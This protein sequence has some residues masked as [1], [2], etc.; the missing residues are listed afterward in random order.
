MRHLLLAT[1]V[2]TTMFVSAPIPA[3]AHPT[4]TPVAAVA[5]PVTIQGGQGTTT[6]ARPMVEVRVGNSKPVPVLLDTGSTGFRST[7]PSSR[8]VPA[9]V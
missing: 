9:E 6:G 8:R 2:S 4:Q 5:V 7:R 3:G 1:L